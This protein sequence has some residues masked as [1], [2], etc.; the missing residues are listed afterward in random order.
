MAAKY[1]KGEGRFIEIAAETDS[2]ILTDGYG[3][4]NYLMP[5]RGRC[6]FLNHCSNRETGRESEGG[7]WEIRHFGL[8]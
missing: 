7:Q 1:E 5:E 2:S 4:G 8:F 6:K 3:R